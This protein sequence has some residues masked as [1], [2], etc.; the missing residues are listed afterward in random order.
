MSPEQYIRRTF[1]LALKG[2]GK[3]W[4][5]PLVG[6][7]IVKNGKVIG[8]GFHL[9]YG[10]DHAELCALKNCSESAAGATIY[11]NLEPC[12]HTNKQTPPCAQRLIE[13]KISKVVICNLDPNPLVNGKGVELLRS[14][15][16][17]V[18][19]GLLAEEGEKLNEVFFLSQRLR[20]PFIYL[21]MASTLDG[22]IALPN[23][24][25]QWITGEESRAHVHTLRSQHQVVMV[26]AE[27][28]RKDN[29]KLNVRLP[30]YDGPQPYRAIIS[31]SG[32]LPKD[33]QHEK[34]LIYTSIEDAMK[35]L[36]ERKLISILLEGGPRLA[37]SFMAK[38]LIDR[39][40]IFLNPSFLGAGPSV[41]E[42]LEL[43]SLSERPF[44]EDLQS[45]TYGPDIF[46]TGRFKKA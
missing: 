30:C 26:G 29:P 33:S 9:Q 15:G 18:Q 28:F 27:T 22:R 44:L 17:E 42:N 5:N 24:E 14:H 21:K 11:V 45:S 35:D 41:I 38:G 7:V 43:K 1:E 19:H 16:I 13:E 39:V 23:G 34:T 25:S 46:L 4:P 32:N 6:A 40:G 31:A 20:R 37:G 2:L 10:H 12:C 8:E 3:T 36:F